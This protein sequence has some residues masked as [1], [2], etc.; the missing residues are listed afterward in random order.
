[1]IDRSLKAPDCAGVLGEA[2]QGKLWAMFIYSLEK[3]TPWLNW[4]DEPASADLY[5]WNS[6]KITFT[7]EKA[8]NS[9]SFLIVRVDTIL[10][11]L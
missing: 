6:T 8:V 2:R 4:S 1:L 3:G 9:S 11:G 10:H 7:K 5:P